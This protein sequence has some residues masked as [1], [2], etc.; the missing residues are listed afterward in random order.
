MFLQSCYKVF[1]EL[2]NR[3]NAKMHCLDEGG[4]L[5]TIANHLE[6]NILL[7]MIKEADPSKN[8]W[9]DYHFDS[10][11]THDIFSGEPDDTF[12]ICSVFKE[13]A[14]NSEMYEMVSIECTTPS[15]YICKLGNYGILATLCSLRTLYCRAKAE[16]RLPELPAHCPRGMAL[17]SRA[18]A[19][20]PLRK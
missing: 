12:N 10:H 13:T 11:R 7:G 15:A 14:A 4:D 17:H 9:L 8:Y 5:T 2:R 20:G 18:G 3:M 16:L 1:T 6:G 19:E